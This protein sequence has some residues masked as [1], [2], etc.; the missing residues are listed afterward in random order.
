MIAAV[1]VLSK[2]EEGAPVL[3]DVGAGA[4][5]QN[6]GLA[7]VLINVA[8]ILSVSMGILVQACF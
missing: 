7:R 4:S 8:M 5:H 3:D 2:N 1:A 6:K